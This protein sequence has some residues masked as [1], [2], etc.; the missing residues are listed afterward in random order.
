MT[1][2]T[3]GICQDGAA[4]LKDGEPVTIEQI[5]AAFRALDAVKEWD[6]KQAMNHGIGVRFTLP[7]HL[8]AQIQGVLE[9]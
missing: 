2:F 9:S 7:E 6:I 3:Q 4:I 5:L 1:E 8:R